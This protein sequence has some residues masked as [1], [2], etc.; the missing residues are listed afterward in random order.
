MRIIHR[1]KFYADEHI[2]RAVINGLQV[3]GLDV[4]SV[5]EFD[6]LGAS[7]EDHLFKALSEN[8]V[9]ITQDTDFL[10]LH[11]RGMNHAGI[12]YA[13]QEISTGEIIRGII[14]VSEILESD[15]IKNRVEFI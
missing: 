3:R 8:R 1:I 6:M 13:Q 11:S 14:L 7:D 12:V 4:K 5:K 15:D 10:R 2:S 9:I